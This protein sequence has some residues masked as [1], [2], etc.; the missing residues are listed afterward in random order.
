M[1][2][3]LLGADGQLG[4]ELKRTSPENVN[5]VSC[6]YPRVDFLVSDS[7][8]DC[9][10]KTTPD[11]IINAAAYTAVDLAEKENDKACRI[12]HKAVAEIALLAA[13]HHAGLVHI[14]T[15]YVFSGKNFKPWQPQDH[16]DPQSVYGSSKLKGEQVVLKLLQDNALVIRTAWLYSSHGKNFVKTMLGLM[17]DK[18]DLKVIDEQVGTPTWARGL[19]QA[20]WTGI[21]NNLSGLYHWTDA[22]VASWYDFAV[23]IQ[24]EALGLG[25]LEN[26]VPIAPVASSQFPTPAQRPFYSVLD[27]RTMW[28]D[29]GITPVHW[30]VMLRSMLKEVKG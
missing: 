24:E 27:K 26:E 6:D 19:A 22:G 2:V 11:W 5:L 9:I 18:K 8:R 16:P 10:L 28:K 15:D 13:K 17:A 30:R 20:V 4:W 14:S 1:K 29:T 25:L 3:L 23:A 21:E 12:N 7:I